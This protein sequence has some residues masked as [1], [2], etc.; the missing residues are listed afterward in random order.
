[1]FVGLFTSN[2]SQSCFLSLHAFG[3]SPFHSFGI[4]N[5]NG[6][7]TYWCLVP[8]MYNNMT[9]EHVSLSATTL[10]SSTQPY[11]ITKGSVY[12]S[13]NSKIYGCTLECEHIPIC[14]LF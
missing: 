13:T 1:M 7:D 2:I 12:Y 11:L 4:K 10:N 3:I 9:I 14:K 5:E 6:M 8:L